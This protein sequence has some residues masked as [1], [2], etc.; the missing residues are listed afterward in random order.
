MT[1]L[2]RLF[3]QLEGMLVAAWQARTTEAEC[4]QWTAQERTE[5]VHVPCALA[6]TLG[7]EALFHG[8]TPDVR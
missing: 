4:I 1:Q 5:D 8:R 7:I 3:G 6:A 2:S